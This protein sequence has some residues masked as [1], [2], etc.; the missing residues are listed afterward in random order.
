MKRYTLKVSNDNSGQIENIWTGDDI[1]DVLHYKKNAVAYW[2]R[3]NVW[4]WDNLQEIMV[5]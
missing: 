3:E 5:G 1:N 2:G 4:I